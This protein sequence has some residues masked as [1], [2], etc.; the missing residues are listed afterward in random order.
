MRLSCRRKFRIQQG[1]PSQFET[2]GKGSIGAQMIQWFGRYI[3]LPEDVKLRAPL[4]VAAQRLAWRAGGDIAF[5]GEVTVADGPKLTL[6]VVRQPQGFTMPN[7][8]IDDGDRRARMTAQRAKDKLDLSFS[9]ELTEQTFDKVFAS[10]PT[11]PVSLRGD[12]ADQCLVVGSDWRL[13]PRA[14][15]R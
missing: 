3:D 15:K 5:A 8:T 7:L 14:I 13:G 4:T 11:Q 10:F 6:D 12:I 9:G 1:R 2:S